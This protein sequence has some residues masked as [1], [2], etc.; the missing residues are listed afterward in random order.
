MKK[1]QISIWIILAIF[2]G[3]IIGGIF[4]LNS[5]KK[6]TSPVENLPTDIQPIYHYVEGCVKDS[7]IAGLKLAALQGGP[8]YLPNRYLDAEY[9][10]IAYAY[11]QGELELISLNQIELELAEFLGKTIPLCTNFSEFPSYE[12]THQDIESEVE[13]LDDEVVVRINYPVLIKKGN[14][15][16]QLGEFIYKIPI[17]FGYMHYIVES[18]LSKTIEDPDWIDMSY[19]S[20]F[21]M[22]IDVIPIDD[23]QLIY[24]I[25]DESSAE[26]FVFLSAFSYKL[27]LEPVFNI[28][29]R[30][31]LTDD[32]AFAYSVDVTDPEGD[33]VTCSD[34]TALFDISES[35]KIL[36]T[37]QVTGEYK[38]TIT[39]KDNH[40]NEVEK[41]AIFI[42]NE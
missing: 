34:D 18:I 24:S 12:I 23:E 11:Y 38:V 30:F 4:L 10:N 20:S 21:D 31:E 9:S 40:G 1:A 35:C 22:K 3:L 39:A 32:E 42:I 28:P 2:L 41:E 14:T 33:L 6:G 25:K 5:F 7:S 15:Q 17:R 27:N 16:N 8:I 26:D 29:E 36:F 19:L 13:I 37:P